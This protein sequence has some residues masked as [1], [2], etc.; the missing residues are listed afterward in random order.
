MSRRWTP[1][2]TSV[3]PPL[4][5]AKDA[6]SQGGVVRSARASTPQSLSLAALTK[7]TTAR[8]FTRTSGVVVTSTPVQAAAKKGASSAHRVAKKYNVTIS[9]VAHAA[10]RSATVPRRRCRTP[11]GAMSPAQRASRMRNSFSTS[12]GSQRRAQPLAPR[13]PSS[14]AAAGAEY[15]RRISRNQPTSASFSAW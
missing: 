8:A 15:Q 6:R 2:T 14:K 13:S 5:T 4:T 3:A 11:G 7:P 9:S 10:P 12:R 1:W